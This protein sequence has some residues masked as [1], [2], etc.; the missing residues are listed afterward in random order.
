MGPLKQALSATI[1]VRNKLGVGR[2]RQRGSPALCV[3]RD[4]VGLILGR[5]LLAPIKRGMNKLC[6]MPGCRVDAMASPNPDHLHVGARS[7]RPGGRCPECGRLSRAVHS[8]YRRHPSDLPSLGRLVRVALRVR[9]FYCRNP[10]CTRRTFAGTTATPCT[11]NL[12][13]CYCP[14]PGPGRRRAGRGGRGEASAAPG[15]ADQRRHGVAPGP[16]YASARG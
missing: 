2:V 8:R 15:Y 10:R 1:V 16:A 4:G 6:P 5:A 14:G 9:R 12:P 11:S 7:T 3:D 13:P